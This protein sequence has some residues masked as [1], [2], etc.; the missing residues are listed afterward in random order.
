M[1]NLHLHE[2]VPRSQWLQQRPLTCV[3][4][5]GFI[6]VI[7]WNWNKDKRHRVIVYFHSC[8]GTSCGSQS[9]IRC[10]LNMHDSKRKTL[11]M[12]INP[13]STLGSLVAK[14]Q[15]LRWAS[16]GLVTTID[17]LSHV[18]ASGPRFLPLWERRWRLL[19]ELKEVWCLLQPRCPTTLAMCR[20]WQL[21]LGRCL[22]PG[23]LVEQ[24]GHAQVPEAARWRHPSPTPW[25]RLEGS[26]CPTRV[27]GGAPWLPDVVTAAL[28]LPLQRPDSRW[29][30]RVNGE[31]WDGEV[32]G[33]FFW[34]LSPEIFFTKINMFLK[35]LSEIFW[36]TCTFSWSFH[37]Q[38]YSE[39][40]RSPS[41]VSPTH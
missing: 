34:C 29:R 14:E 20:L 33:Y 26:T 28:H 18:H 36:Q 8:S 6:L 25:V 19:E 41:F 21:A 27:G 39:P 35:N 16:T 9:F 24:G 7:N 31:V 5:T 2:H 37:N 11:N 1:G 40:P 32:Y 38:L 23:G 3:W 12:N 13:S 17:A 30:I 10:I 22:L 15:A 4:R